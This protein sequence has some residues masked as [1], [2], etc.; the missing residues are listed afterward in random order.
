MSPA[1]DRTVPGYRTPPGAAPPPVATNFLR[2]PAGPGELGRLGNYRVLKLLGTGGMGMV[3]HAEDLVL[4]RPVAL[5][6]MRPEL[7]NSQEECQRFLREARALAA[8][9]HDNL[10]TVY[11]AGQEGEGFFIAMELLEGQSLEDRIRKPGV[12]ESP[13]ILRIAREALRGLSAIHRRGLVHRDIKPSNLWLEAPS[14]RVRILDFGLAR[15]QEAGVTLTQ[16]GVVMG[17]PAFMAPEQARGV[18]ADARSDLFSLGAVL[19]NMC[20]GRVP[21]KGETLMAQLTALAVDTP[22]PARQVNPKIPAALSDLVARL[23]SKERDARPIS[24]DAVLEE[25]AGIEQGKP[26]R[27]AAAPARRLLKVGWPWLPMAIGAGACC[28]AVLLALELAGS[29]PETVPPPEVARKPAPP[30]PVEPPSPPLERR[31]ERAPEPKPPERKPEPPPPPPAEPKP[32][33]PPV[34][35]RAAPAQRTFLLGIPETDLSEGVYFGRASGKKGTPLPNSPPDMFLRMGID[36]EE[37]LQG[38]G[39]H[40]RPQGPSWVSFR[41]DGKFSTF[42]SRVNQNEGPRDDPES[43]MTFTLLGDG[44]VLWRSK[45]VAS[46]KDGQPCEVSVRGVR[47]LRL[48][49]GCERGIR[50]AHGL[51]FDPTLE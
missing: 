29:H 38:V 26:A 17:T 20:T 46:R 42:R 23:L 37:A 41:L 21:F 18:P 34:E 48:E 28:L 45:P 33:P 43:P 12:M 8:I 39:M 40:P 51:W 19:Y 49:V 31:P 25:L 27:R 3:F 11:Q 13:E 47:L 24:A 9:K 15:P 1:E 10:V 5:K 22:P 32:P 6:V 14:G 44:T 35:P 30:P 7:V 2:P 50:A 4:R 16:S 36:G